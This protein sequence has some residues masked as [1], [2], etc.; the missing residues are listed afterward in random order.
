MRRSQ[1]I[2]GADR[3]P[4]G[5]VSFCLAGQPCVR[6]SYAMAARAHDW[7]RQA[8][9]DLNHARHALE[10]GDS[11]WACFAAQQAAERAAKAAHQSLGQDAWG[12][13]VTELLRALQPQVPDIDDAVVDAARSLDKLY[14]ATRYPN[15]LPSG[16]PAD[17][18]TR[19][20][21]ARAIHEAEIV[22]ERC[23]NVLLR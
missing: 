15:G 1:L 8:E 13:S 4:P 7:F 12:H 11:E 22:I 21:A 14:I 2:I 16:A 10:D 5:R 3:P 6:Y 18:Y 9:A 17:Y 20:E 19:T 23:R